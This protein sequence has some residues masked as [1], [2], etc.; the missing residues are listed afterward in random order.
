[1]RTVTVFGAVRRIFTEHFPQSKRG[2]ALYI[3][4]GINLKSMRWKTVAEGSHDVLVSIRIRHHRHAGIFADGAIADHAQHIE[5]ITLVPH[6]DYDGVH[7]HCASR[8]QA[9][10]VGPDIGKC[11]PPPGIT[12]D[13]GRRNRISPDAEDTS[14]IIL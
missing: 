7:P 9:P 14:G 10:L 12:D 4:L 3:E 11:L 6:V 5:E 1:K 8:P 2:A 13:R